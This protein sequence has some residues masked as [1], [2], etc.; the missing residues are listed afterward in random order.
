MMK[1]I[2]CKNSFI[3]LCLL[4]V[5]LWTLSPT[6][7][8]TSLP[9]DVAEGLAWGNQWML[10][11]SKMPPLTAWLLAI[12]TWGFNGLIGLPIYLLAQLCVVITYGFV[13]KLACKIAN[14]KVALIAVLLLVGIL[15]Y[16]N[17]SPNLTPDT[18]STP[19]WAAI[20]YF[21]YCSFKEN[22]L[23]S[24]CLL[25]VTLALAMLT[26]YSAVIL[27]FILLLFTL[28]NR[29]SR[30]R[31]ASKGPYIS[32]VL[33]LLLFMP[34]FIWEIQHH[35][36]T[37]NYLFHSA[38]AGQDNPVNVVMFQAQLGRHLAVLIDAFI[39]P[40]AALLPILI[41]AW[42]LWLR[43]NSKDHRSY[44]SARPFERNFIY[45]IALGPY[46]L[47][48]LYALLSGNH[49]IPRWFT[50]YFSFMGLWL[51]LLLRPHLSQQ[52]IKR[53][54]I[55]ALIL[56]FC[57][58]FG[59]AIY[60]LSMP[61]HKDTS[62]NDLYLNIPAVINKSEKIWNKQQQTSLK[63]IAGS[64]YLSAY[65]A[66]YSDHQLRPFMDASLIESP[67]INLTDF[68]Q[69]GGIFIFQ[70]SGRFILPK[71]IAADYPHLIYAGN[72]LFNNLYPLG[73][74]SPY[75]A[76]IYVAFYLLPPAKTT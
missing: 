6:L 16:S 42:P 12:V 57:I 9:H 63:Y 11:Y 71:K 28:T 14:K 47:T 25:G 62:G 26:K 1:K 5:G 55:T 44:W 72:Y 38:L 30:L 74:K 32:M 33:A 69:Q 20:A 41:I 10:G 17:N 49:V 39:S 65:L 19:L 58:W 48:L 73:I 76:G 70:N 18:M 68:K 8:Y 75:T 34:H 43:L 40:T 54:I 24:W 46:L 53:V 31:Y 66:V 67:W 50:P 23:S 3:L 59:R 21:T 29:E 4:Q 2:N 13:W 22:K 61:L 15:Y 45:S 51:V 7:S 35:F 60:V 52:T 37:F 36:P 64:H 56:F 27:I